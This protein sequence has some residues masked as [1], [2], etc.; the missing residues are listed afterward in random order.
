M[1]QPSSRARSTTAGEKARQLWSGSAPTRSST[2]LPSGS[3]PARSSMRRP[4][5]PGVDA[6]ARGASSAGGPGGRA[7]CRCRRWRR[8]RARHV[9]R[10]APRAPRRR[11]ARRRSSRRARPRA[12]GASSSG[13]WM[14]LV[15]RLIRAAPMAWRADSTSAT[16]C[17][18]KKSKSAGVAAVAHGAAD[19]AGVDALD[20]AGQLPVAEGHVVVDGRQVAARRPRRSARAARAGAGS[21]RAGGAAAGDRRRRRRVGPVDHQQADVGERVA[22]GADLPVEHGDDGAVG[23]DHAVV[24]PVVAVDDGGRALLGDLAA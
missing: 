2:S 10:S 4:G 14:K 21:R 20:D 24:E 11:P 13:F 7:A 17:S 16:T 18:P 22:E 3:A 8:S 1:R 23:A 19:V 15:E 6:V 12:R 9:R 5:E